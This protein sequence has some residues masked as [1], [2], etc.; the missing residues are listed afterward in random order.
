MGVLLSVGDGD[1]GWDWGFVF[2]LP[3]FF[4]PVLSF[5]EGEGEGVGVGEG[6]SFGPEKIWLVP[7]GGRPRLGLGLVASGRSSVGGSSVGGFPLKGISGWIASNSACPSSAWSASAMAWTVRTLLMSLSCML[8][9]FGWDDDVEGVAV[10]VAPLALPL[11]SLPSV[12]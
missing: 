1:E 3:L 5:W 10:K 7:F 4:S 2:F 12:R 11:C 6:D 8:S 9:A